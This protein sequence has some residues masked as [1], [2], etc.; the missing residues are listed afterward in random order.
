MMPPAPPTHP[1]Y[2]KNSTRQY[3]PEDNSEQY[4]NY[5]FF[6][7]FSE[8]EKNKTFVPRLARKR[9]KQ[10]TIALVKYNNFQYIIYRK[11][12]KL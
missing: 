5:W 8:K 10:T 12:L 4:S 1:P 3:I 6:V 2:H 7:C 9:K 11:Y